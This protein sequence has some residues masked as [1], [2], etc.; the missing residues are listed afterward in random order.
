[1]DLLRRDMV[2]PNNQ[3]VMSDKLD[4]SLKKNIQQPITFSMSFTMFYPL[5]KCGNNLSICLQIFDPN[6]HM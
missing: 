5:S 2:K 6:I 3:N 1:M 4:N